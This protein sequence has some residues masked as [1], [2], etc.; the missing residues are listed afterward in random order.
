MPGTLF[1]VPTPIGHMEDMTLR[2]VRVLG[3]V[4]VIAAEDTRTAR[5][6]MA[7]HEITGPRVVS[8][9]AGNEA[10]REQEL[11]TALAAGDDVA[12]ISEA[13]MPSISD[14][15][16]RLIHAAAAAGVRVEVLPGPSA[17]VTALVGSGLGAERF[18]FAGFLPR[19]TGKRRQDIAALARVPAT[20]VLYEAPGR[21]ARTL[22]EL[23]GALGRDRQA[24]VAREL[25]KIHEEYVRGSLGELAA[26]FGEEPPR[27]ECVLVVAAADP[28][29]L[30]AQSDVEGEV[31]ALLAG[32]ASPRDIAARLTISTGIQKRKLYQLA[33]ALSDRQT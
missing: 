25:T 33:L 5:K 21:V 26:R 15:G 1:V 23:G 19:E 20:L 22:E 3:E 30:P 10:R 29:E 14:P 27:G 4:Q 18:L 16:Q 31:R 9:F 8:Y 12:V 11:M 28:D 7:R 6:L 24:C 13:G 17:A 32:G 2:A